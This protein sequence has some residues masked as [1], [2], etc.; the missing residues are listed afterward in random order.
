MRLRVYSRHGEGGSTRFFVSPK[1][2]TSEVSVVLRQASSESPPSTG[3]AVLPWARK[4]ESTA[5]LYVMT[6]TFAT[7]LA[8]SC[9]LTTG[10]RFAP[11]STVD[12]DMAFA[13][14]RLLLGGRQKALGKSTKAELVTRGDQ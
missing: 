4:G 9:V 6:E 2:L 10:P 13:L 8:G 7:E 11:S 1:H 5:R 14:A 3:V 12:H